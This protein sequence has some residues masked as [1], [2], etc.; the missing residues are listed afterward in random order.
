M[1]DVSDKFVEKLL[2]LEKLEK[3]RKKVIQFL[4]R[5][6][7]KKQKTSKCRR[8]DRHVNPSQDRHLNPSQDRHVNPSKDRHVNRSQDRH[9]NPSH[10]R[11]V[12]PTNIETGS[13]RDFLW[14]HREESALL[15]ALCFVE[16]ARSI[17]VKEA[18]LNSLDDVDV[19]KIVRK[20]Q[21]FV[22]S[23]S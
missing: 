20:F 3:H 5:L 13:F 21:K 15:A 18:D 23:R 9:V 7:R 10:D 16:E 4:S 8:S 12:K 17:G 22:Q 6:I 14:T 1:H 11:H 2:D 19:L